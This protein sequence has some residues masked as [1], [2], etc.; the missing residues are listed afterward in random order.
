MK[1]ERIDVV[2]A[3]LCWPDLSHVGCSAL[4]ADRLCHVFFVP[5]SPFVSRRLV[6]A[7]HNLL[8]YTNNNIVLFGC[9]NMFY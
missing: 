8:E 9:C 2:P 3:G 6:Q 5:D 1:S 7:K 4:S